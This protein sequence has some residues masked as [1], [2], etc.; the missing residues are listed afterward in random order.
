MDLYSHNP[1]G[2]RSDKLFNTIR[3]FRVDRIEQTRRLEETRLWFVL[4]AVMQIA[5]IV[6]VELGKRCCSLDH[7]CAE[8]TRDPLPGRFGCGDAAGAAVPGIVRRLPIIGPRYITCRRM[9]REHSN[10]WMQ[11]SKRSLARLQ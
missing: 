8:S 5:V 1:A 11:G 6:L 7:K 2:L 3:R 10:T 4:E 9:V